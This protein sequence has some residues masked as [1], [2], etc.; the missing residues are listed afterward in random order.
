M[1][2]VCAGTLEVK[3]EGRAG[4]EGG[5]EGGRKGGK[6]GGREGRRK[7]GRDIASRTAGWLAC[8]A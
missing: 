4:R 2:V 7:G 6:E 8:A 3:R 5:W 1:E